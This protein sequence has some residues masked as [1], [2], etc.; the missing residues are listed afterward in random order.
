MYYEYVYRDEDGK[1]HVV[2]RVY[3]IGQAPATITIEDGD[4]VY[5]AELIISGGAGPMKTNWGIGAH[6]DLPPENY[7]GGL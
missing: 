7:K 2:E 1:E 4:A 6:S 5:T 3:R